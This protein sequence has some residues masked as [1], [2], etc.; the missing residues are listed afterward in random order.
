MYKSEDFKEAWESWK[1]HKVE[2]TGSPYTVVSEERA[3]SALFK[4]SHGVEKLAIDSIDY[5]I[6]KN[7]ADIYIKPNEN[8]NGQNNGSYPSK[9]GTSA[10]RMEALRKW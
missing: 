8:G 10:D 3:L 5:S 9:K 6:E 1:R 7:W 2:K 4:K